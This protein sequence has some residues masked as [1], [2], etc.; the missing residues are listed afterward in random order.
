M[1][2]KV[3]SFRDWDIEGLVREISQPHVKAVIYFFSLALESN[4]PQKAIAN[5]FPGAICIGSSM[6]GGWSSSGAVDNGIV[7]MSLSAD[8]VDEVYVSFQDDV[9]K[10]TVRA[11]KTAIT[12]LKRQ[13]TGQNINPDE[14]LG[15]ILFD[16][17]CMGELI[18]K[19]FSLDQTLN[20]AFVGGAAMYEPPNMDKTLVS[21]G[22]RLSDD[23]LV[24]VIL[25]MKIPFFFNHYVHYV[26]TETFFTVSKADAMKRIVWEIDGEDAA[27]FYARQIGIN[28][29]DKL[30]MPVFAK[31]PMGVKFGDSVYVRSPTSIIDGRGIQFACYLKEGTRI[32]MMEQ[33]D[34]I[35][36]TETGLAAAEQFLPGIQGTLLFNCGLRYYEL[37]EL[38]KVDVF[39]NIF[40]KFPMVGFNT[41]GEE[42]FIHHNQTLTA[43]F[44][45][46]QMEE[47]Y[48]DP[49]KAK[50]FF[51]YIYSKL[52]ALV[53]DII[54]QSEIL[55]INI[56]RLKDS[57]SECLKLDSFQSGDPQSIIAN[58][59]SIMHS[60]D[61]MLAQ[62]HVSKDETKN[63]LVVY[64]S[65]MHKIRKQVFSIVDE[66]RDQNLR[67]MELREHA[68]AESRTKSNFL[69]SMSHEIRTPMNAITGMAELLLR[70]DLPNETRGY[71]QD[72]KQAGANLLAIINDLL[73]FS[74]IEAGRL[75]IIPAKYILASLINDVVSIIRM[76]VVEKPIRFYTNIDGHI[77]NCLIG[78]EVRIRQILLNLLSNAVKY[79]DRG[80]IGL[81]ITQ[82]K[83]TDDEIWF[84]ITVSDTGHGIKPEDQERLFN[85][86]VQLDQKRS[87]IEGTGLGLSIVK[88]L[89]AA[90]GGDVSVIS[91]YGKGSSFTVLFPQ[92]IDSP[93]P[94]AQVNEAEK[95]KVLMYER[96]M[97]YTKSVCWSLENM[98]VPYALVTDQK[99][100]VD[101]LFREEWYFVFSGYG[102]Y[103]KIKP[104]M[105][106]PRE[107]FPGGKKPPLAL[108]VEWGIEDYIPT[109]RFVSIPVQSLSIANVLNGETDRR[110]YHENSGA[111]Q[112]MY[113]K[114]RMLVVDDIST[115]LK[116]AQGLL[117][118]YK[119]TVDICLTGSEAIE[120]S[121]HW[122]YDIIFMDH[123]MPEMDGIEAT[124]I[125]RNLEQELSD[126][127]V[128][129]KETTIVALTANA[130]SGMRELFIEKGFSD[131]L[132]KP[133]D[134]SKLDE[135]LAEWIPKEKRERVKG[136]VLWNGEPSESP[137][138]TSLPV[139][140]GI[141]VAKGIVNTGGT[142][143]NYKQILSLFRR[144]ARDRLPLLQTMPTTETLPVFVTQVHAL[145]SAS[146][147][148][149]AEEISAEAARLEKAGSTGDLAF[150]LENIGP[151]AERLA[152]MLGNIDAAL[153]SP[154]I[155]GDTPRHKGM[156]TA[157]DIPAY[158]RE[159]AEALKSQDASETDRLIDEL[160]LQPLDAKEREVLEKISD[161]VLV[162]E[163][164]DAAKTIEEYIT[165]NC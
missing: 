50:R 30:N 39:N 103:N 152:Q 1:A 5:A 118:P 18:M 100:F 129:H 77:P 11:A 60:L 134:V 87:R 147:S 63:M 159:L 10:D 3:A 78:D 69:A 122:D 14:Y 34:I 62:S 136:D 116:V 101:A 31:Y 130:V 150:F 99:S 80:Q 40:D 113:P 126:A 12:E 165:G 145:K 42:L 160:D 107:D 120:L 94:F 148:L 90:M 56:A 23:G 37:R 114:A 151:F 51:H 46:N 110:D 70:G 21:I 36:H 24:V 72:I 133:I 146:Q 153:G 7:A 53:F 112:Y 92:K 25:K 163:F 124:T 58:Y 121:Q 13:A 83:R 88:K 111:I 132:A 32:Y 109:V 75:E 49:Y 117:A 79:T 8:E 108:M 27:I 89:C 74:K 19:E 106:R 68:E 104:I 86:F 82:E 154:G 93:E 41:M 43:V 125:I 91:E 20:M 138:G 140:S 6:F 55:D 162:A 119:A 54:G 48:A 81:S 102:L 98:K 47:G 17:L 155:W 33:G 141:D 142:L 76:R 57:V 65:N 59:E 139:I 61:A 16:G 97:I 105:D 9:K 26:P 35:A 85:D 2:I 96:R 44:F 66:I 164:D 95:K 127:G 73:D 115:N 158:L 67:L 161:A 28:D 128:S 64:Q 29:V 131:F 4:E 157:K 38:D 156:K 15:L 143:A 149:G 71:V 123:M 22:D 52:K 84:R 45:G 135:I 137:K 144:D